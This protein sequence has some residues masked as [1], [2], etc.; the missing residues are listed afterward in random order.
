[1]TDIQQEIKPQQSIELL[2]ELEISKKWIK[3]RVNP[4]WVLLFRTSFKSLEAGH[5]YSI[6]SRDTLIESC[7]KIAEKLIFRKTTSVN[8]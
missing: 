1:M 4:N 7:K 3:G 6:D 5:I 2:K 8:W